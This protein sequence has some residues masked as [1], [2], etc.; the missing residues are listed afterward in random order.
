MSFKEAVENVRKSGKYTKEQASAIVANAS[1]KASPSAKR[2]NPK[3]N[4]VK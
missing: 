3:L 4:K 1:R 2:R